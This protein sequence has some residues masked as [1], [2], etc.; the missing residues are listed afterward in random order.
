VSLTLLKPF[1]VD[2]GQSTQNLGGFKNPEFP[3]SKNSKF[4]NTNHL[5]YQH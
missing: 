1:M 3:K 2:L 5:Y 4:F